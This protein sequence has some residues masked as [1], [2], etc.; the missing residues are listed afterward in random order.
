MEYNKL[1][2]LNALIRPVV[3]Y[4]VDPVL[5]RMASG[6]DPCLVRGYRGWSR[7]RSQMLPLLFSS[8]LKLPEAMLV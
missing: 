3:H 6:S 4:P 5:P 1:G 7:C 8:T 2:Y